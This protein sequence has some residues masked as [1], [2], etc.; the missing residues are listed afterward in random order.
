MERFLADH[1]IWLELMVAFGT[2]GATLIALYPT[3]NRFL[4]KPKLDFWVGEKI[5]FVISAG[6][7][8]LKIHLG[9]GFIN[10]SNKELIINRTI[11]KIHKNNNEYLYDWNMF[12]RD[13]DGTNVISDKRPVPI[14]LLPRNNHYEMIQFF[15]VPENEPNFFIGNWNLE[16]LVWSN[17]KEIQQKPTFKKIYNVKI[18]QDFIDKVKNEK[19]AFL[20]RNFKSPCPTVH[21]P[22]SNW[23]LEEIL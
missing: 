21:I 3:L 12:I 22:F 11:I 1:K 2:L 18:T 19:K 20:A 5:G 15:I 10:Q 13:I 9:F 23:D 6:N 7:K 14:I 17:K 16:V 8:L 4:M